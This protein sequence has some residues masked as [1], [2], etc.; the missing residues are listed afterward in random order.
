MIAHQ[1]NGSGVGEDQDPLRRYQVGN[2]IEALLQ[3]AAVVEKT[4]ELLRFG[5]GTEGPKPR[6]CSSGH[7]HDDDVLIDLVH[8]FP[9]PSQRSVL[10]PDG[11]PALPAVFYCD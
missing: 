10:A 2:A 11:H 5:F 8:L 9:L 6:S 1:S 3:E 4:N 7:D